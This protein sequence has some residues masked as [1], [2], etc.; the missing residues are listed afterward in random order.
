MSNPIIISWSNLWPV[1]PTVQDELVAALKA[2]LR[3]DERETCQHQETHREG[4][5]WEVCD[6]CEMR[7]ADDECGKPEWR[8]PPEWE[9]ARAAIAKAEGEKP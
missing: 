7:W 6:R 2:L 5:I 8:D 4:F 1:S 3:R 9:A